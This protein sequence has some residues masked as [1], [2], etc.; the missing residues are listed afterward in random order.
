MKL[1]LM[2]SEPSSPLGLSLARDMLSE[3]ERETVSWRLETLVLARLIDDLDN[4]GE[5]PM[6]PLYTVIQL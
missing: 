4:A 5:V 6:G 3:G 1:A 2:Y